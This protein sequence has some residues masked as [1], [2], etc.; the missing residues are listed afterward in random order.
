MNFLKEKF[1][2]IFLVIGFLVVSFAPT[3]TM[4]MSNSVMDGCKLSGERAGDFVALGLN[5]EEDCKYN[6]QDSHCGVC[7]ILNAIYTL[8]DWIFIFLV[9]VSALMIIYGAFLFVTAGQDPG[10]VDK[11]KQ[12]IMYACIGL[13]VAFFSKALPTLIGVIIGVNA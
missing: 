6:T 13:V 4:A 9:A 8:T 12:L 5:C 3:F 2:K 7:C 1:F 10:N 11:A